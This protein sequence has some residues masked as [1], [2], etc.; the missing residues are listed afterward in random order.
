M[1]DIVRRLRL[2]G[3]DICC[4]AA[5]QIESLEADIERL[6]TSAEEDARLRQTCLELRDEARQENKRLQIE[7][8]RLMGRK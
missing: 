1:T 2:R 5:E 6:Q 3:T 4:E 7:I 8:E